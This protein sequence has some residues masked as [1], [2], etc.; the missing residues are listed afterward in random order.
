[1]K[2]R[3]QIADCG[4]RNDK[5]GE[6]KMERKEMKNEECEVRNA[7]CGMGIAG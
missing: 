5:S 2:C 7:D 1:M 6:G 4:M 3:M